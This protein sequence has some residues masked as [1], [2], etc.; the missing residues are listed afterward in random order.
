MPGLHLYSKPKMNASIHWAYRMCDLLGNQ[1]QSKSYAI[2]FLVNKRFCSCILRLLFSANPI[3]TSFEKSRHCWYSNGYV[4]ITNVHSRH[5]TLWFNNCNWLN[6]STNDFHYIKSH[7]EILFLPLS[8]I[9]NDCSS[10]SE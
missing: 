10:E 1:L 6:F 5:C 8:L 9:S 7:S 2:H 4:G 3:L